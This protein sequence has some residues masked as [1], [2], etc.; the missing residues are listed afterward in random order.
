MK[1]LVF[2]PLLLACAT[3]AFSQSAP[4]IASSDN[5]L[6]QLDTCGTILSSQTITGLAGNI[7]YNGSHVLYRMNE[8]GA[9]IGGVYANTTTGGVQICSNCT[10]SVTT[11]AYFDGAIY[12]ATTLGLQRFVLASGAYEIVAGPQTGIRNVFAT[13]QT[14]YF[15]SISGSNTYDVRRVDSV[16]PFATTVLMSHSSFGSKFVVTNNKLFILFTTGHVGVADLTSS[17]PTSFDMLFDSQYSSIG[18]AGTSLVLQ[19]S[20]ADM[21][22]YD[23]NTACGRSITTTTPFKNF[24]G[25]TSTLSQCQSSPCDVFPSTSS[26]PS[27]LPQWTLSFGI[28]ASI[29]FILSF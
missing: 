18:V 9:L 2:V 12:S 1:Y 23:P 20:F 16:S 14:L 7:A 25:T 6:Y 26:T 3:F 8:A 17:L 22:I 15:D 21:V 5:Q 10:N 19:Y 4:I 28:L 13:S 27:L 29:L 24:V 11:W